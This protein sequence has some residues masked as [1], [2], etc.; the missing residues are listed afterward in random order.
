[1]FFVTFVALALLPFA[2]G[3]EGESNTDIEFVQRQLTGLYTVSPTVGDTNGGWYTYYLFNSFGLFYVDFSTSFF[4]TSYFN[5][6]SEIISQVKK[7]S[8]LDMVSVLTSKMGAFQRRANTFAATF[9]SQR[10]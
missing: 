8:L 3:A 10:M 9:T 7:S 4:M 6:F 5:M 1:M 2:R